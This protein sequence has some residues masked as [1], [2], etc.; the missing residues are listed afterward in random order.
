MAFVIDGGAALLEA[1]EAYF[2]TQ[3][4]HSLSSLENV[5]NV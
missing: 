1:P 4:I 2:N 5:K 3:F